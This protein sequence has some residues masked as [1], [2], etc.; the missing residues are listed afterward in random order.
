MLNNAVTTQKELED[1]H[2]VVAFDKV[3]VLKGHSMKTLFEASL[4]ELKKVE[5][6]NT[7]VSI[8][9]CFFWAARISEYG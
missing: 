4:L 5:S 7:E 3:V 1:A 6:K 2:M 9:F 8:S